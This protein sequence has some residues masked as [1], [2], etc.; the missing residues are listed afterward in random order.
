M[1]KVLVAQLAVVDG[2]PQVNIA[3]AVKII[4]KYGDEVDFVVFPELWTTG[5]DREAIR[6][7]AESVDDGWSVRVLSS[8]AREYGVN[9]ISTVP[10]REGE[11]IY[12]ASLLITH[13][14]ISGI[15]RKIH[16][17]RPYRENEIF[18]AGKDLGLFETKLGKVGIAICYDL[19]FP[20]LFRALAMGGAEII[21][22]PASWGA[23]RSIQWRALLRGRAAE[24]EV[25]LVG[26]NRVGRSNITKEEY[27]GDSSVYDPFGFEVVHLE[28]TEN[29]TAVDIDLKRIAEVRKA[30]P[31]WEDRRVD[32]YG[33]RTSWGIQDS[34]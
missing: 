3:K 18:T 13:E 6:K 19:R 29:A 8:L 20:E 17:F 32:L 5:Y 26:V 24:N 10:L 1:V 31:L 23:P 33:L 4:M 14:G 28:S 34:R 15:Y 16:L 2:K 21:F 30:L 12:D 7:Y 11:R 22:V 9:I 25:F 27:S